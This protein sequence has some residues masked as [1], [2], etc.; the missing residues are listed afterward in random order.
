[1]TGRS[2]KISQ[3]QSPI[4]TRTVAMLNKVYN[5]VE[6]LFPPTLFGGFATAIVCR[7]CPIGLLVS[8][9]T[10][11]W[12]FLIVCI[13]VVAVQNSQTASK[14]LIAGFNKNEFNEYD[15]WEHPSNDQLPSTRQGLHLIPDNPVKANGVVLNRTK[16]NSY[17]YITLLDRLS[18]DEE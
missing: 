15:Q 6:R 10:F 18:G 17:N 12:G 13:F 8:L 14:N 2:N 11:L 4:K 3:P 7:S 1:M 9:L 5:F 16:G